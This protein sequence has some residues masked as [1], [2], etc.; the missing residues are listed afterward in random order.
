MLMA[1]TKEQVFVICNGSWIKS[2][3]IGR[4]MNHVETGI[5]LAPQVDRA[6]LLP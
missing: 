5:F 4:I 1:G 3:P 6:E 2:A